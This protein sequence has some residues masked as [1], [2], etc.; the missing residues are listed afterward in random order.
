[1]TTEA[2]F[3]PDKNAMR[4]SFAQAA[5]SYDAVAA[6]QCLTADEMLSRLPF[7]A[8]APDNVLDLGCGTGRNLSL[9]QS[10]YPKARIWAM[11]I[12]EAMLKYARRQQGLSSRLSKWLPGRTNTPF[13]AG[14]AEQLPFADNSFDLVFA[15]LT[16]QWCEPAKSFAELQRVMKPS[17]C[18]MFSTLGPDTLAELREAWAAVDDSPHVNQF[19]DMHDVG[20][21][22]SRWAFGD[23]VLDVDMQRFHF[24]SVKAVM[25]SLKDLGAHN[26]NQGRRRSLTGKQRFQQMQ[27]YYESFRESAGLPVSYEVVYGHGWAGE[28]PQQTA[29]DGAVHVP[30]G[31]I[32]RRS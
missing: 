4:S 30:V 11:D 16:L 27:A 12:A 13:I 15:N 32:G 29:A 17:G 22:M 31:D 20:D 26:V 21:A 3:Q 10:H 1:M 19:L 25:R 6:L 14:D 9:L 24:A 28:L 7:L 18:L 2:D 23:V 8:I 5:D